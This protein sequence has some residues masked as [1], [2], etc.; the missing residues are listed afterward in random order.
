MFVSPNSH[1]NTIWR[2]CRRKSYSAFHSNE[3]FISLTNVLLPH[4]TLWVLSEIIAH[5]HPRDQFPLPSVHILMADTFQEFNNA[6]AISES[7]SPRDCLCPSSI[8][9]TVTNVLLLYLL[10]ITYEHSQAPEFSWASPL[11]SILISVNFS[12]WQHLK[13]ENVSRSVISNSY[14]DPM[15]CSPPGSSVHGILQARILEWAYIS[16]SRGSS[17]PKDW[18]Q[19]SC[20]ASKFFTIWVTGEALAT[21]EVCVNTHPANKD[22]QIRCNEPWDFPGGPVVKSSPSNSGGG[23]LIP[24]QGTKIPFTLKPKN[25]NVEQYCNKFYKD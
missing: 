25:Q 4:N 3:M 14:C 11:F 24:G 23:D 9:A 15:D 20:L 18:T 10:S 6:F 12:F 21:S 8:S 2:K 22:V 19:L 1:V 5:F 7:S 16:F 13:S 17:W